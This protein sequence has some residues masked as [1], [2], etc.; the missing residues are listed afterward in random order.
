M[1]RYPRTSEQKP[2]A[3]GAARAFIHT[4]DVLQRLHEE[5]PRDHFTLR[6]PMERLPN[7]SFGMIML[8]LAKYQNMTALVSNQTAACRVAAA[9]V[10]LSRRTPSLTAMSSWV[11]IRSLECCRS[12][13]PVSQRHTC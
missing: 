7:R 10:T 8:L 4:S 3:P 1:P 12:S 13:L 6:W 5:A 2:R 11:A 9:A